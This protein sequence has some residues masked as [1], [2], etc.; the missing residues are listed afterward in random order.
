MRPIGVRS[1]WLV[2][3]LGAVSAIAVANIAVTF[4]QIDLSSAWRAEKPSHQT[5]LAHPT[6][7]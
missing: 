1:A 5:R 3:L 4:E 7:G 6:H 2:A